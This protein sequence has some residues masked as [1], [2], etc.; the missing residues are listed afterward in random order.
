MTIEIPQYLKDELD[1]FA[2][3]RDVEKMFDDFVE[4]VTDSMM[5]E[6]SHPGYDDD[7]GEPDMDLAMMDYV[8]ER[9]FAQFN[10]YYVKPE[11]IQMPDGGGKI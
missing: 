4:K 2:A 8:L 1:A 3:R 6:V 10:L 11:Y 5:D 9:V 7:E